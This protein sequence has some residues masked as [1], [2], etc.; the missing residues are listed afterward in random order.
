[1]GS[2]IHRKGPRLGATAKVERGRSSSIGERSC[3]PI[4][5]SKF[6]N[7]RDDCN[8]PRNYEENETFG[9]TFEGGGWKRKKPEQIG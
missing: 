9:Q 6:R 5:R 8:S 3:F 2:R 7:R 4:H 1:L